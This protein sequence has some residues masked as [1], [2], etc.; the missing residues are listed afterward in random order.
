M[1]KNSS[2]FIFLL[3]IGYLTKKQA[4][5]LATGHATRSVIVENQRIIDK[6]FPFRDDA[7]FIIF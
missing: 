5:L 3:T 2:I 7:I 6:N 4:T 1:I